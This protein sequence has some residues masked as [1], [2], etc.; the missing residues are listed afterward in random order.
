[1]AGESEPQSNGSSQLVAFG[2]GLR[3]FGVPID[4][5]LEM[6]PLGQVDPI[7]NAPRWILGMMR[8][9]ESVVP[10]LD[11]RV[12]LG[13]PSL[14][15]EGASIVAVVRESR[16]EHAAWLRSLQASCQD[17]RAVDVPVG[18]RS[19]KFARFQLEFESSDVK[20]MHLLE[21]LEAP[22][23]RLH[24]AVR[25]AVDR[26]TCGDWD[27]A[28]AR[29]ESL[30]RTEFSALLDRFDDVETHVEEG[31]RRMAIV[32]RTQKRAACIAVDRVESVVGYETSQVEATPLE[33]EM[34]IDGRGLTAAVVKPLDDGRLIQVLDVERLFE[35]Y[36]GSEE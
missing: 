23:Q 21:K 25:E 15:E 33:E 12:R 31:Q 27:G 1:M 26:T 19:C 8:L 24:E 11:L 28:R 4:V 34:M 9:R 20:L 36:E 16:D 29:L 18:A 5:V 3:R 2:V 32:L 17:R 30:R 7:P 14:V 10:V 13:M 35:P 6:A 22:H